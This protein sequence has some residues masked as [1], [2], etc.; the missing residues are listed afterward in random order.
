[1][2]GT[3]IFPIRIHIEYNEN[4]K[5]LVNTNFKDE[6]KVKHKIIHSGLFDFMNNNT[7]KKKTKTK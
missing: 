7:K 3:V 1:M 4:S 2:S 5:S 6:K